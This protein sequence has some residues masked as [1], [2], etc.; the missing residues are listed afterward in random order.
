MLVEEGEELDDEA[1][2]MIAEDEL[3]DEEDEGECSILFLGMT[4]LVNRT[5]PQTMS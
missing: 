5:K 2:A 3:D 1:N 4:S